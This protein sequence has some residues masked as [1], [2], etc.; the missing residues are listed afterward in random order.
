MFAIGPMCG[1]A[2]SK[3]PAPMI[4]VRETSTALIVVLLR[5][6]IGSDGAGSLTSPRARE[7]EPVSETIRNSV[8]KFYLQIDCSSLSRNL[9]IDFLKEDDLDSDC[10]LDI[11]AR[12]E[13]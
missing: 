7:R 13:G 3:S 1:T 11:V 5:P 8:S 4:R 10:M 6:P 12:F 2:E 9:R